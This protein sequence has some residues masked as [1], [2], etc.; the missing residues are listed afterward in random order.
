MR[1]YR[2][3]DL[4]R[5]DESGA[6]TVTGR[7]DGVIVSGGVNVSLGELEQLIRR[8]TPM[9]DAVVVAADDERWGQVPV[10]VSTVAIELLELRAI[11]SAAL[12]PASAPAR[13]V[14]VQSIPLLPS[15]KPDRLA[16]RQLVAR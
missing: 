8:Q 9:H 4:G 13:V 6:L 1:W 12:G 16:I 5:I 7:L 3:G 14:G 15:G 11:A 2:T 10:V